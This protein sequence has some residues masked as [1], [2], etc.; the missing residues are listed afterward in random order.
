M[1]APSTR[2]HDVDLRKPHDALFRFAF[3]DDR[4]AAILLRAMLMRTAGGRA[5]ARRIDWS[6]L[7]RMQDGFRDAADRPHATD[8]WFSAPLGAEVVLLHVILEHKSRPDALTAWQVTRYSVRTIDSVHQHAGQPPKLPLV[9]P[10]VVYHGDEPWTVARDVRDLFA[11]PTDL[12]ADAKKALRRMLPSCRYQLHDLSEVARSLGEGQRLGLVAGLSV[13]FLCHMRKLTAAELA[14][15]LSEVR[16][17]LV[18]VQEV[19]RGRLL[20][21]MLFCY[22]RATARADVEEIHAAVRQTLP[23]KVGDEMLNPLERAF[24]EATN[25]GFAEGSAKGMHHGMQQGMQQGLQQGLHIGQRAMLRSLLQARFG[26]LSESDL[27]RLDTASV[28]QLEAWAIRSLD[29]AT[30]DEVLGN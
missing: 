16:D 25:R 10:I 19:P 17:L 21:G 2:L 1:F 7:K 29:A 4:E 14:A 5:L 20:L 6:R 30:I 27:V 15:A 3:D 24:E 23:P 13:H 11:V 9:V 18:A 12:S 22:L 28:T 8:F 26:P